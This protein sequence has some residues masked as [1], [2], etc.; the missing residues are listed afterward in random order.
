MSTNNSKLISTTNPAMKRY[1]GES[2]SLQFSETTAFFIT[3][4]FEDYAFKTSMLMSY[5]KEDKIL[6]LNTMNSTYIFEVDESVRN[7]PVV[8]LS[9]CE[10]II[11]QFL[12]SIKSD[13]FY[14]TVSPTPQLA[15]GVSIVS[16][17][18]PI[19]QKEALSYLSNGGLVDDIEKLPI[20]NIVAPYEDENIFAGLPLYTLNDNVYIC[21]EDIQLEELLKC[22]SKFMI[23][24][25][26]TTFEEKEY[27]EKSIFYEFI[28]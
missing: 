14:C 16:F 10:K 8:E 4:D 13:K 15:N 21:V 23:G 6:T 3:D 1:E 28:S 7:P 20:K 17:S 9:P 18:T 26:V 2:G 11:D 25:Q 24:R 27:I 12:K 19:S 5:K 22:L